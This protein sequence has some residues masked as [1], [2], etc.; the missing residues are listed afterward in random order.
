M[1][2]GWTRLYLCGWTK[3]LLN[4]WPPRW[5]TTLF[6]APQLRWKQCIQPGGLL[7]N[8]WF[9]KGSFGFSCYLSF[10]VHQNKE[11]TDWLTAY[12]A[13]D[14]KCKRNLGSILSSVYGFLADLHDY[15]ML[16]RLW[17]NSSR[18]YFYSKWVIALFFWLA[19]ALVMQAADVWLCCALLF[20]QA[21]EGLVTWSL[22]KTTALC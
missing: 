15:E 19:R 1:V 13:Q 3:T 5:T 7:L 17:P 22:C 12:T 4:I 2:S 21:L 9:Y 18:Y 14:V 16:Y 20:D 11:L 8:P 10:T 6:R